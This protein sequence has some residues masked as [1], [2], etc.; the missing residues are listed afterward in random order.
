MV[1]DLGEESPR[2]ETTIIDLTSGQPQLIRLGS[3]DPELFGVS[4]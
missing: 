3:G 1:A 4:V 2:Q